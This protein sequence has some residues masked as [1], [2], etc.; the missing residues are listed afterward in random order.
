MSVVSGIVILGTLFLI[1][2]NCNSSHAPVSP[3]SSKPFGTSFIIHLE[4]GNFPERQHE[5]SFNGGSTRAFKWQAY[6]WD[7]L[8]EFVEL[9]DSYNAKLTIEA[10]PQWLEFF[11]ADSNRL[12]TVK[13]WS[14]NGHEL[15]FQ[16]HGADHI[17]WN[18]FTNRPDK[19]MDSRYRGTIEDMLEI[20]SSFGISMKTLSMSDHKQDFPRLKDDFLYEVNGRTPED[21][22]R[23]PYKVVDLCPD[24]EFIQ[25]GMAYAPGI[26]QDE[27]LSKIENSFKRSDDKSIFNFVTHEYDIWN[28]T[29]YFG[30]LKK[31]Q[32]KEW[33]DF[34]ESQGLTIRTIS[35]LM[36]EYQ[37]S[38]SI[39]TS[40]DPI[41]HDSDYLNDTEHENC[42]R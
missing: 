5:P 31:T 40:T 37:S 4:V 33:L 12:S 24:M 18:G 27:T 42:G 32:Y 1:Y 26:D 23:H 35:D 38:F 22:R 11:A 6:Y 2:Q 17:D 25:L 8:V 21:G 7:S 29:Q 15:A 20:L 30:S 14:K 28:A 10:N 3:T 19:E 16:H 39:E 13:E 9:A 36:E 41:L 34:V